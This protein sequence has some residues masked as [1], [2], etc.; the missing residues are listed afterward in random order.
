MKGRF[1]LKARKKQEEV[2]APNYKGMSKKKLLEMHPEL[3]PEMTKKEII[4]YLE[5]V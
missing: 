4:N 2:T 5:N 3:D 1:K